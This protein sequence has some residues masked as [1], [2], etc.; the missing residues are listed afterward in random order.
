MSSK[1]LRLYE[2][3]T[4]A[5]GAFIVEEG[6]V[7]FYI[8]TADRYSLT[9]RG[10]I[11]GATEFILAG[12]LGIH[13]PRV[14][15]ALISEGTQVKKITAEKC[16]EGLSSFPF[17]LNIS[18]VLARQLV[19]TNQVISK[20]QKAVI[21][22]EDDRRKICLD[23]YRIVKD[24]SVEYAKRRLPWLKD[25]VIKYETT[26]IYKEGEALSRTAEPVRI[27]GGA[28]LT[29]K[30]VEYQKDSLICEEGADGD[31]MFILQS[32]MI[33]VIVQGRTVATISDEGTPIGEIAL[34]IGEKRSA[35]L[36]AK[37]TVIAAR[38][39]KS[40]LAAIAEKDISIIRMIALSL[41]KKHYQNI[42]KVL[43]LSGIIAEKE[44]ATSSEAKSKEA[45]KLT[46]CKSDLSSL[47]NEISE[48]VFKKREPF[49]KDIAVKYGIE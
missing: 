30:I 16:A 24:L 11:I 20:N 27:T 2:S 4:P 28:A 5:D 37:N 42:N 31:E 18:I 40:D 13:T 9:G 34:L 3:G 26:I 49:L 21:G 33:D 41:A 23:Y 19:L 15:T 35:T 32:G 46:A 44:M 7:Y 1:F 45:L 47:K 17:L 12:E 25:F 29:G 10:I 36:K 43:E 14:E 8:T 22:K 38:L 39:K 48:L 6:D